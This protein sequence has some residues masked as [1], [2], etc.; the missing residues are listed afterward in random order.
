[1][2]CS[3]NRRDEKTLHSLVWKKLNIQE[4][5]EILGVD[6]M[7]ILKCNLKN[8]DGEVKTGLMWLWIGTSGELLGTR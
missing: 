1:M 3:T 5:L 4:P 6:R 2:A 7:I 8:W